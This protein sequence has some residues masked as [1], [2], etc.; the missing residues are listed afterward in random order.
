MTS[1]LSIL[2]RKA[3]ALI[4]SKRHSPE[5]LSSVKQVAVA[6]L[7]FEFIPKHAPG[8]CTLCDASRREMLR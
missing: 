8:K 7:S 4:L 3:K 1:L 6:D 2:L 5:I